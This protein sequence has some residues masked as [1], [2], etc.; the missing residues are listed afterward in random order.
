MCRHPRNRIT[1]EFLGL[2]GWI[3]QEPQLVILTAVELQQIVRVVQSYPYS[4]GSQKLLG[5]LEAGPV[6]ARR[7][8]PE[9][10]EYFLR[11]PLVGLLREC[12]ASYLIG[13][14]AVL[15]LAELGVLVV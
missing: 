14:F 3:V 2:N 13:F 15:H 8:L 5:G 11:Q 7:E 10:R 9:A 6:E 4:Y 12:L 1:R